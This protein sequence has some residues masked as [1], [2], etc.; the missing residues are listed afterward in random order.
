M[1]QPAWVRE[2]EALLESLARAGV[3]AGGLVAIVVVPGLGLGVAAG[4]ERW[5]VAAN[6]PAAIVSTVAGVLRP[7]WVWWDA[8]TAAGPMLASGVRVRACWDLAAV[9]LVLH[10]GRRCDPAAVWAA[11]RDLPDPPPPRE[12]VTLLNLAGDG[13]EESLAP[14]RSDGQ[15]DPDWSERDWAERDWTLGPALT[16]PGEA[17]ALLA[18]AAT[19]A[20]LALDVQT[21]QERGL[22]AI[23]DPRPAPGPVPLAVVTAYAE[24]AA[25]LLAAELEYDGLPLDLSAAESLIAEHIGPRPIDAAEE[26][27]VRARRDT[28]VLRHFPPGRS[29]DLRNPAQVRELLARIGLALPDTRSWRLE[30]FRDTHPGVAALL[31]WRKAERIAT[32]YGY[33]WLD[34]HVGADGRLR[35]G[36]SAADGGAGRMTA[37][38]GLHN[39][40]AGFRIAVAAEPDQVLVRA[41]LGQIEP[42]VLAAVSGDR[43][44]AR[45]ARDDDLYAP[46]AEQL[47]CDRPTAK[48]AV[49]AAMYGQ[50]SGTAGEALKRME[51]SYPKAIAYLRAAEEAGQVG[52]DLRTFGGRL[53]RLRRRAPVEAEPDPEPDP[54]DALVTADAPPG[55]RPAGRASG[56]GRFARNAVIQGAAAELF[57]AWAASV[58]TGL[59]PLGGRV[60]LCLHDELLLHVPVAHADA[61]ADL[62]TR[63]LASTTA[64]WAAGSGVRFVADVAVVQRWSEAK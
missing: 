7:R 5:A 60:V 62:L 25:A 61:A 4:A 47:R 21:H 22:R 26:T 17:A 36:W 35:G 46:V 24:S 41:D 18:Q 63:S 50:T 1:R 58:R 32:T 55:A 52:E 54:Q 9:H 10:G 45:A 2:G 28:A 31:E 51:R 53:L 40:P 8:R 20:S 43:A 57:K 38:A 59:M 64:L 39:L 29:Y 23:P 11:V 13:G 44:L 37:G 12:E 14:I 34:R 48:V 33:G 15:L 6:D 42:R 3:D 19:W 30:P 27:A 49:L 16:R 56:R